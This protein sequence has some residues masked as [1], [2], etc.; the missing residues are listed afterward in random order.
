MAYR[1]HDQAMYT[2][3]ADTLRDKINSGALPPGSVLPSETELMTAYGVSRPTARA[4]FQAL[5]NQG[6]I[7]VIH[8]KGSFVRRLDALPT[9]THTRTITCTPAPPDD[10]K[11]AGRRTTKTNPARRWAY[12]D[13]DTGRWTVLDQPRHSRTDATPTLALALVIAEREP[14]FVCDRLLG[15]PVTGQRL[16]H[17]LYLPFAVCVEV[18][19]LEADP[20]PDPEQLYTL[21]DTHYGE[22]RWTEHV[23]ARMPTPDETTTLHTPNNAPLLITQRITH[24][25]GGRPLALEQTRLTAEDTQLTY[26][27]TAAT[28]NASPIEGE[29]G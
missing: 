18:P 14:L 3:L 25:P 2:Q 29:R 8:G 20:F 28:R 17:R 24:A 22:L 26:T 1:A 12:T 21:L 10:A 27:L 5:R 16:A 19:A 9:H 11:R 4:A 7:T 6:L 13:T 23:R 15:D